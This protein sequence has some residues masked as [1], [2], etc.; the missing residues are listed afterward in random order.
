MK[1]PSISIVSQLF[2]QLFFHLFSQL[3][4][5]TRGNKTKC[6]SVVED[7][8]VS[9]CS[10]NSSDELDLGNEYEEAG[11]EGEDGC[12]VNHNLC[13]MKN[14]RKSPNDAVGKLVNLVKLLNLENLG[15]EYEEPGKEGKNCCR[16]NHNLCNMKRK[17]HNFILNFID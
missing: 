5:L 12:R 15:N 10:G 3:F 1:I 6:E 4:C 8:N 11:K 13:N 17:N 2:C 7:V 9:F 16:V 14:A